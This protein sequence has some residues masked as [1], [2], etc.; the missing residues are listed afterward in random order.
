M[1]QIIEFDYLMAR[2]PSEGVR[3]YEDVEAMNQRV[4]EWLDTP[5]GTVADMPEWGHP[6]YAFKHEPDSPSLQVM[7]EMMVFEKLVADVVDID[8]RS[9]SVEFPEI[10][11]MMVAIVHGTGFLE[12]EVS[13]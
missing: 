10:D 11:R 2:A 3:S 9:V 13:L 12:K 8:L 6:F 4:M 1:A 7:A 5:D